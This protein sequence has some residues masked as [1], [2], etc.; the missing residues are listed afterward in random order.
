MFQATEYLFIRLIDIIK[1]DK[2]QCIVWHARQQSRWKLYKRDKQ[3]G[4]EFK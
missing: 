3:E 2:L 1:L 4:N